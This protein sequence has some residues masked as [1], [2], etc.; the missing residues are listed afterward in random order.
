[1]LKPGG[2]ICAWTPNRY[3]PVAIGARVIPERFHAK[4]LARL[5]PDRDERDTFP[6]VYR[7]N[8][9]LALRRHFPPARFRHCSYAVT[10]EPRYHGN[11]LTLAA[12]WEFY[13][14]LAP[15]RFASHLHVFLQKLR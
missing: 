3:G 7:L 11:R 9:M 4:S 14:R 1:M 6:T 12:A 2:W 5:L 15:R 8:T 10:G 13:R